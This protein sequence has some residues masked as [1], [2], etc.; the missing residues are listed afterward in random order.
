[1]YNILYY[2]II[3]WNVRYV[4]LFFFFNCQNRNEGCREYES[5]N[6]SCRSNFNLFVSI[7]D[8][9]THYP[10]TVHIT[11]LRTGRFKMDRNLDDV[12][13]NYRTG[14][15]NFLQKERFFSSSIILFYESIHMRNYGT[16]VSKYN[17]SQQFRTKVKWNQSINFW[18]L[19]RSLPIDIMIWLEW[20]IQYYTVWIYFHPV[21]FLLILYITFSRDHFYPSKHTN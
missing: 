9:P 15:S 3:N 18:N 19:T 2:F 8:I 21:L 16:Y 10:T 6:N 12:S 7:Y 5:I 1:M 17:Y 20:L 13:T 14:T 11:H 4:L